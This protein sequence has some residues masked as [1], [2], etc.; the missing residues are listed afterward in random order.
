VV[1]NYESLKNKQNE[2]IRKA[3]EG[4]VFLSDINAPAIT[5]LTV[6]S[7]SATAGEVAGTDS[8]VNIVTGGNLVL[9]VKGTQ[10]TVALADADIPSAVVTKINAEVSAVATAALDGGVLE[11]TT[12]DTGSDADVTVV[13]GTG[14]ILANLFLTAGQKGFGTDVGVN[15]KPLP[16][17]WDDLGW[18]SNDGAGFSRDVATS[19][20]TSWGSVTP[21][22]SDVTSD[23]STLAV[24]AQETK[25]LTIGLATGADLAA[26]TA[27][28]QTGEV[29][30][31]KPSRP[32]SKSYRALSL[33]VD[34]GDGGE[35]YLG[36]FLPRAKVTNYAEQ[37]HGGGDDPISWGV[38]LTGEEDSNLGYSE[39]WLFGGPGW[40]ALLDDMGISLDA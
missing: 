15:L 13:S 39:R 22:R 26:I 17:G 29:S 28:A 25:L 2:L 11:I 1:A 8:A 33:A 4:S 37:N 5:N 14:T 35:I 27:T 23:T 12:V 36:R 24:T 6:Y 19:D 18:L 32:S 38:T 40:L 20:V 30:I 3:L 31:E 9:D 7:A 10:Y 34:V 21:T 16:A